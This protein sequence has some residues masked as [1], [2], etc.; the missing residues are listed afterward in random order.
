MTD[1]DAPVAVYIA[2]YGDDTAA[3]GDWDALKQLEDDDVI[4]LDGLLLVSRDADGKIDVKDDAHSVKRGTTIGAVGG[5][6]VG[7]IFPPALLGSTIV[8]GGIGASIAGLKSHHDK[9]EIKEDAADVLPPDSSGIVA[10]FEAKWASHV[11]GVLYNADS[12]T[13]RGVDAD[14]ANE[15]KVTATSS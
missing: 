7:L 1:Q 8:G 12:V 2:A 9:K 13:K 3:Q 5:A 15:V 14:S 11:D 6:I 4:E 10:M